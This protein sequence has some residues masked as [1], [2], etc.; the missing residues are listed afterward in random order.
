MSKNIKSLIR[1]G[2]PLE[3]DED[4]DWPPYSVEHLWVQP[5]GETF[6]VRSFPFFV[7][8]MAFDDLISA[9]V[10]A[11]GYVSQWSTIK[12]SSNSTIWII[13]SDQNQIIDELEK[14]GCGVEAGAV[15]NSLF[16]KCPRIRHHR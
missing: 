14:L 15:E 13:T 3:I 9:V 2:F 7:K 16:D 10:D 11:Y 1:I 8:G 6:Y 12:P 4:E 5:V